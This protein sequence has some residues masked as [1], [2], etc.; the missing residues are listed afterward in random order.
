M[1]AK[2]KREDIDSDYAK[3]KECMQDIHGSSHFK[4][5]VSYI[6]CF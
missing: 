1:E 4:L 6:N 2:Q 5:G 3:S